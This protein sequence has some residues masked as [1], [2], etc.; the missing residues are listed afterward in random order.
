[1]T[2][3]ATSS[4][5][6]GAHMPQWTLVCRLA[7]IVPDT[8]VA[9]LLNG[10]PIAIFRL[11]DDRVYAIDNTDPFSNASVLSRGILGDIDGEPVVASPIYKQHFRLEDGRCIE[12]EA[13]SVSAYRVA[14]VDSGVI[15]QLAA[16]Q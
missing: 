15:V 6:D 2:A 10:R 7:D 16:K 3:V 11:G 13:M 5:P 4:W 9:A 14:V 8:G 12:D 1:M